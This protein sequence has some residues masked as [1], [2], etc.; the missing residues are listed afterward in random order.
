MGWNANRVKYKWD[1]IQIKLS[2]NGIR[3]GDGW[4]SL[5]ISSHFTSIAVL[6]I[7]M[8][9]YGIKLHLDNLDVFKNDIQNY[10]VTL[11]DH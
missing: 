4:N 5:N 11:N 2:T 10:F 1:E 8:V 6:N 9:L 7:C 3:F